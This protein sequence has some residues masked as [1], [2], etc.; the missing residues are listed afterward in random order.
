[1]EERYEIRGKL[2]QGGL[3]AV[4]RAW[5]H[6]LKREVA[7]KRILAGDDDTQREEATRQMEKETGAL[8]A[9]QHPNIVTIFDVGSD[10]DGPFVV[11]ELLSGQTLDEIVE[12]APLTWPD[13]RELV[14]QIQEALI[15]AQ[16]LGLI[17][18]D[19]K[20]SNVMLNWLP[21]GRFQAKVVDFGLANF[22]ATPSPGNLEQDDSIFGSIFYMAPELFERG[23]IDTRL[24]MYAIGCVYYFTLTGRNP[25]EGETGPQV[26]AAHLDH[27]VLPLSQLR[28]DIP[29]W[30]CDWVMWHIN[31]HP[32][33][34]PANARET[35]KSFI[36][37]DVPLTQ[38]MSTGEPQPEAPKRP[39][40][41]IPGAAPAPAAP[42]APIPDPVIT[43]T[44]PQPLAPPVGA[45]PS[46]HT[47]SQ[48]PTS[49]V[50]LQASPAAPPPAVAVMPSPEPA[51]VPVATP[52][53]VVPVATPTLVVPA[54]TPTLV[55]PAAAPA[56]VVPAAAPSLVVPAAV[57]T[58]VA[59]LQTT[60]VQ[61]TP[62][63]S[64]PVQPSGPQ[65]RLGPA[66]T[67][68]TKPASAKTTPAAI[69]TTGTRPGMPQGPATGKALAPPA[70]PG[71]GNGAKVAIAA[72]LGILVVIISAL[73]VSKMG[74]SKAAKQ[75]N[76]LVKTAA[77]PTT[78]ELPVDRQ[79]LE[80]LLSSVVTPGS[81]SARETVYKALFLAR[82]TDGTDIDD[83]IVEA[84]IKPET[85]T[86]IRQ[87]LLARVVGQRKNPAIVP[88]LV[89]F[90][91]STEDAQGAKAALD[92]VSS[93]GS[94][95]EF[96][97]LLDVIQFTGSVPVRQAAEA[98]AGKI[99]AKSTQRAEFAAVLA[100]A[101]G[102]ATNE[103]TRHALLRLL[104]RAG[105][106]QAAEIVKTALAEGSELDRQTAVKALGQWSDDSMFQ[107]LTGFIAEAKD[108]NLRSRAFD[109]ALDFLRDKSR[110][111]SAAQDEDFWKTLASN[112][113]TSAE[114]LAMIRA[115][116]NNEPTE[117]AMS[118][119]KYFYD[120]SDSD[121]VQDLAD[122]ALNR[123]RER[124]KVLGGRSGGDAPDAE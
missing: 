42:P 78:S 58:P 44:A 103:D 123:M 10:E 39:R 87:A 2:G 4:Y 93:L 121:E 38:S 59:V 49:A 81:N 85:N 27:R 97:L 62:V 108:E 57:P 69:P 51:A 115:L 116:A 107:T 72:V 24:D 68:P 5:D 1:M 98:S 46:V 33:E 118:V 75:F 86:S 56:P 112:A 120:Q 94:D 80:T 70:K 104:G 96:P 6:A 19:L 64:A 84:A 50:E 37:L 34:R 8:A 92:A 53:L 36:Q 13:F 124:A 74:A 95:E 90:A 26:M 40:L 122:K 17:H 28:P 32:D 109:S 83:L 21:S 76:E 15:A 106:D 82:S 89:A 61:A 63:P 45:P 7:V 25:F 113:K 22:G 67:K 110:K 9:L 91:R 47:S 100:T 41:I 77:D 16:D 101:Y 60:A 30:A 88:K 29:Q 71:L 52:T 73:I 12:K 3:G 79:Q 48:P 35:L 117:W 99:I 31:R 23:P 105:G 102:T 66:A 20:P 43:Q 65:I 18:R 54:A 111:R 119:V 114:Q 14:L 11:M 55:V